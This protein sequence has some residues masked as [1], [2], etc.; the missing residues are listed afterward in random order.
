MVVVLVGD[1]FAVAWLRRLRVVANVGFDFAPYVWAT[2]VSNLVLAVVLVSLLWYVLQ[3]GPI[4]LAVYVV[5]LV[6]GGLVVMNTVL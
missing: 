4:Y 3:S 2:A 5:Y 6:V 1:Y